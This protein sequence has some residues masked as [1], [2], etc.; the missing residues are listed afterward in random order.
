LQGVPGKNDKE[1]S[2]LFTNYTYE[3]GFLGIGCFGN[4][5][6]EGSEGNLWI[7]SND[8]LTEYHPE[9]D[10]QDSVA[11]N[12]QLTGIQLHNENIRWLDLEKKKDTNLMLGNGICVSHFRFDSISHWNLLPVNFNLAY[13][14]N[15]LTFTFVGITQKQSSKVKY[16]YMLEG[17]DENWSALTSHTEAPYGNI[18]H[19]TYTF[20]VKAMNSAG[21]WSKEFHYTFTIRPP[22]WKTWWA[23]T[24]YFLIFILLIGILIYSI[25]ENQRRKIRLIVNERNRISKELHDDIGAELTRLTMISQLLQNKPDIDQEVQ[26]K[27][28]KISD[29]G[30]KVLGGIGEIIWTMNPRNDNL[31]SL[32]AYIR[33]FVTEYL[34]TN[35]IDVS[36]EFPEEI[37]ANEVS[38]EYRRNVFLAIKEAVSNIIK[39]SKASSV[40]LTMIIT[41]KLAEFEISDNGIGFSVKEKQN[42]GN[43]LRNMSE[44]MK[45]VGGN[46]QISSDINQGTQI[47]LTFPVQ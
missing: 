25:L 39:Y 38:D 9:G 22:W 11:P 35:G 18:P 27:L 10:V 29:S 40:R 28:R 15:Y 6:C 12:I 21:I 8:R 1:S 16:R 41:E 33:R 36:I 37:P 7:G 31:D 13:N 30:K 17:L 24:M 23:Y 47:K 34:E 26:D 43:G 2:S 14:N 5:M 46:F 3:D 44:R 45:D 42:S 20:K 19:G 32:F 4:S